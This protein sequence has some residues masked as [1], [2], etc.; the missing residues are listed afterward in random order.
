MAA[1][2]PQSRR[3]LL[4]MHGVGVTKI[5]RYGTVFLDII[6]KYCAKHHIKEK[7]KSGQSDIQTAYKSVGGKRYIEIGEAYIKTQSIIE[8]SAQF[9]IKQS[10]IVA[11]LLQYV[12][13]GHKIPAGDMLALSS[14]TPVEQ[15]TVFATFD[16]LGTK[17]LKAVYEELGETI[18]YNKLYL[19]RVYY[20]SQERKSNG[21]N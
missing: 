14:L 5:N 6:R 18:S 2:F 12:L 7:Q 11:H 3:S 4:D 13:E 8:L 21:K 16:R 17:Y 19:L 10:T 15:K 1:F 20:L 9:G